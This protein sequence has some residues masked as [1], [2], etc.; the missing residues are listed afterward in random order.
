MI[1]L[2][3]VFEENCLDFGPDSYRDSVQTLTETHDPINFVIDKG[4]E[5]WLLIFTSLQRLCQ[6]S[7]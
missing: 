3:T 2:K 5:F 1:G 7:N 4:Y 6:I